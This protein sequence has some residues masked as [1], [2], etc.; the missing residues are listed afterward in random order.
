MD[1]LSKIPKIIHPSFIISQKNKKKEYNKQKNIKYSKQYYDLN[2]DEILEKRKIEYNKNKQKKQEY[3]QKKKEEILKKRKMEYQ[4][5][6]NNN[7]N[8]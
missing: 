8:I 4:K 3:Y 1:I 6:I 7:N 5:K 2:K